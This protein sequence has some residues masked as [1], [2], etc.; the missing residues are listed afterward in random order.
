MKAEDV[1]FQMFHNTADDD[2]TAMVVAAAANF[3][4]VGKPGKKNLYIKRVLFEMIDGSMTFAKFG[5]LTALENGCRM[6]V[7]DNHGNEVADFL[8]G[9]VIKTNSDFGLLSGIDAILEPAAGDDRL[10]VRWSL[11]KGILV[12]GLELPTDWL[13]RF[14]VQDDLTG[15]TVFRAIAQGYLA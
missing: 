2:S 3:D 13:L 9:E 5:G 7:L 4:V 8:D 6:V 1:G 14:M 10:D 11:Y 15:L 12:E